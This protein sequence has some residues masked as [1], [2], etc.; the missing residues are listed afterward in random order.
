MMLKKVNL[1]YRVEPEIKK[2]LDK[3]AKDNAINVSALV[4]KLIIEH[5]NKEGYKTK[6]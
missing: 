6:V 2:V 1:N 4:R 5:L 3:Y